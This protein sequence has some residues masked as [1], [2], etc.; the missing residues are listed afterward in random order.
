VRLS[1][2]SICYDS[3]PKHDWRLPQETAP[4]ESTAFQG[5]KQ[6]HCQSVK[7]GGARK[8]GRTFA[9]GKTTATSDPKPAALKELGGPFPFNALFTGFPQG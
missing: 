6:E 1:G 3:I 2:E 8:G 7:P 9:L 5:F 4:Y